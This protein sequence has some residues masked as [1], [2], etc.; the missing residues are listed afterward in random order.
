M[1]GH[2]T[3]LMEPYAR[4]CALGIVKLH[5]SS[6]IKAVL[7]HDYESFNPDLICALAGVVGEDNVRETTLYP[8][9]L[10]RLEP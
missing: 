9:D 1:R 4:G 6:D 8:R 5:N 7:M 3:R 10:S 2:Y